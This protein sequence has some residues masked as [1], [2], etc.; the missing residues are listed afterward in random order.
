VFGRIC[1]VA[2]P[3]GGRTWQVR[4]LLGQLAILDWLVI[5]IVLIIIFG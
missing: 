2:A 1:Q 5:M 4:L 3:V